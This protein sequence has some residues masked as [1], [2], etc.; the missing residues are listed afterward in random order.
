V[1]VAQSFCQFE[2]EL[3]NGLF[4]QLFVFL[5]KFKQISPGA[6]FKHDP[7]VVARLVP[8]V[9]AEYVRVLEVVED[10]NFVH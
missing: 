3:F 4:R 2:S 8:V 1:Q 6:V 7:Q 5:Q 9:K 10:S